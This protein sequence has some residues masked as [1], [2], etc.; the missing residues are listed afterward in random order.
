MIKLLLV[1]MGLDYGDIISAFES[2]DIESIGRERVFSN[3]KDIKYISTYQ[4]LPNI[5]RD[6]EQDY[7]LMT[8]N[9]NHISSY[10]TDYFDTPHFEF[11][12]QHHNGVLNRMKVRCRHY[13]D[14]QSFAEVKRKT[15]KGITLKNRIPFLGDFDDTVLNKSVMNDLGIDRNL[16][17]VKQ[18]SVCY[19]RLTFYSRSFEEKITIDAELEYQRGLDTLHLKP[20]VILESKGFSNTHSIFNCRMKDMRIRKSSFSKYCFGLSM[21]E[22]VVKKNNFKSLHHRTHKIIDV[23]ELA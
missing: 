2:M 11:Y 16:M 7:I 5:I 20:L 18:L 12:H 1:P 14:G 13:A 22:P 21:L 15:N 23:Y 4:E 6:I 10:R 3:R 17:L 9:G 19:K 8:V